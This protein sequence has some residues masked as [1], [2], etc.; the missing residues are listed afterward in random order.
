MSKYVC[1]DIGGTFTD[2]AVID[3]SGLMKVFKSPTTHHDYAQGMTESLSQAAAFWNQPL[4]EFLRSCSIVESGTMIHGSTI[5]TNAVLEGKV[6]KVGMIVTQGHRD[7]LLWREGPVKDPF[8]FQ[9]DYPEPY[10]PRYLTFP[11][12]ERVDAE[13]GIVTPLNEEDVR[14]AV[15]QFKKWDVKAIA[16][17]LLWSIVNPA[18]EQR[19]MQIIKEEWS[20][21]EVVLSSEVNPCLREY[22][23]W[24]ST[25]M[26]A[27]LKRIISTYTL[28]LNE[29]MRALGFKGEVG[30]LNSSGGVSS[31]A[32]IS[33]RPLYSIDSGP[34]MAPIIGRKV[35][36]DDLQDNNVVILDMGGTSF[37]VSC[38][39]NG[40]ISVSREAKIGWEIPGIS[41]VNVNSIGAGGGSIAWV[42]SG[43]MCRVGP[44]SAGSNPGPVCYGWGGTKPTVTDANLIL[45]YLNP[46]YFNAGRMT[47]NKYLAAKAIKEHIADPMG[48]S[49][50]EAA[51]TIWTT[52]N[53]NMVAAIKEITIWQGIDPRN[54]V[55]VAG[56]GACGVHT[57]PLAEGLDMKKILIPKSAGALSASGGIFSN[58][59]SEHSRSYYTETRALDFEKVNAILKELAEAGREFFE[60]NNI[61]EDSRDYRFYMEGRY[62]YQVWEIPIRIDGFLN[63]DWT[64]DSDGLKKLVN[65]FHDEHDR[66]FAVKEE[67]AYVECIFWRIEAVGKRKKIAAKLKVSDVKG[68]VVV[69]ARALRGTRQ[70]YFREAGGMTDTF[71]YNGDL[72]VYGNRIVGP[73]VIEEDTTTIALQPGYEAEV[74]KF[75]TYCIKKI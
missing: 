4:D 38:V 45:G 72:I 47:L 15:R 41:R 66:I 70:A 62:P 7:V 48:L 1:T 31:A 25:A 13:G 33:A 5:A 2:A 8:D 10:I 43:G 60:R 57:I 42:D 69:D 24:V 39:L 16:V 29:R 40:E 30:M 3:E 56:G 73:A 34:A 67:D 55:M 12:E 59:V 49:V 22:R 6:D 18:H 19:I 36:F 52:I 54:Y 51:F 26:D 75:G 58:V 74:T 37:D 64:L 27:S 9:I 53:A 20:E 11:V 50:E 46:E 44:E 23:R 32:E 63:S 28:Q 21:C 68:D 14:K 61:D 35:A 65:R 71:I 17:C